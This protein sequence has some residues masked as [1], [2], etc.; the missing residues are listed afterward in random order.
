MATTQIEASVR[1]EYRTTRLKAEVILDCRHGIR[2]K[3][4]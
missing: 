2:I 1:K 4:T 3:R